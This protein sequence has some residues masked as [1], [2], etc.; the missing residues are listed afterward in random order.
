MSRVILGALASWAMLAIAPLNGHHSLSEYD[1]SRRITLDAL[2]R[3]FHFVN[4]HPYLVVSGRLDGVTRLWRL[5][6]DNRFE[7][8]DVGMTARTFA[9]DDQLVVSGAPGHDG[10]AVLYVREL[11]RAADGFRYEQLGSSPRI[12]RPGRMK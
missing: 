8:I 2:V 7:L 4:P 12:V 3:E 10:K 1:M 9:R 6:M 5:E 11:D